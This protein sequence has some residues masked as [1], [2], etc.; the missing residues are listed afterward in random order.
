MAYLYEITNSKN[1]KLAVTNYGA[2]MV[3]IIV[4]DKAGE[5][6]DVL[7]G[8]DLAVQGT[9]KSLLQ[10]HS[11]K[12]AILRRSAFFTVQLSHPYMITGKTSAICEP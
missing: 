6:A 3:N 9:L 11:S 10:C 2:I 8:Y 12:A 4:P 5:F 1:A 7:L